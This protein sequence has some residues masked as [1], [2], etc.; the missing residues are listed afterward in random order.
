MDAAEAM[1]AVA[2]PAPAA[3]ETPR[4]KPRLPR[5][6]LP[7]PPPP[8][9]SAV[10]APGRRGGSSHTNLQHD[11]LER[12]VRRQ[13]ISAVN[14]LLEHRLL[15]QDV[16]RAC[17]VPGL[18]DL[19]EAKSET[20]MFTANDQRLE[21]ASC[22]MCVCVRVSLDVSAPQPEESTTIGETQRDEGHQ[23][24][25]TP[26]TERCLANA[27]ALPAHGRNLPDEFGFL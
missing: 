23:P 18:F 12:S 2:T 11:G 3:A 19:Y 1:L 15:S 5:K 17:I 6:A 26:Q 13:A 7:A 27:I 21:A 22:A 25:D 8:P 14:L 10:S 4:R 20:W 9:P 16:L 24:H